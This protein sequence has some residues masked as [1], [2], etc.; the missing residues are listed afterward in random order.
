MAEQGID[1]FDIYD[2]GKVEST[3]DPVEQAEMDLAQQEMDIL[4]PPPEVAEGYAAEQAIKRFREENQDLIGEAYD[5]FLRSG[6]DYDEYKKRLEEGKTV[7]EEEEEVVT[8][9]PPRD[10]TPQETFEGLEEEQKIGRINDAL[11]NNPNVTLA[12]ILDILT[13]W[14]IPTDLFRK[15]TGKTPEEYVGNGDDT[16]GEEPSS[17]ECQPGYEKWNGSCVPVCNAAA[18]YVRDEA[19][20]QCVLK[21]EAPEPEPCPEGYVYDEASQSCVPI[22]TGGDDGGN[23]GTGNKQCPTGYVYDEASQSCVPEVTGGGG[24]NDPTETPVLGLPQQPTTE[25]GGVGGM[26][27]VDL[28]PNRTTS[29]VLAPDL[30]KLDKNIPLIGKLTNYVAPQAQPMLLE[31]ISQR[32]RT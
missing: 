20:G 31:G 28:S 16:G 12:D 7:V 27:A 8:L 3:I 24:L 14:N 9:D 25:P 30:F 21:E 15:A 29:E 18:G 19:T 32:Y 23:G 17:E 2:Q 11:E 26:F 1:P 13:T 10:L 6:L 4:N 22:E 5:A